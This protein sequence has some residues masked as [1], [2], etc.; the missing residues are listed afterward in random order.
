MNN[1]G[2]NINADRGNWKFSGDMIQHFPNHIKR[3]VPFYDEGHQLI[4]RLSDYFIRSGSKMYDLGCSTG[5]LLC[6]LADYHSHKKELSFIGI[7]SEPDMISFANSQ[8]KNS[9]DITF[10]CEDLSSLLFEESSLIISYYCFQFIRPKYR[11]TI[12]DRIYNALDWGGACV[13]FDKVRAPD[14]RFQDMMTGI[15]TDFKADNL[16]TDEEIMQKSRSLRGVQEPYSSEENY[17]YFYRAGFK[18][19]MTIYKYVTFEG[20]LAIK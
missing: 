15:Y 19:V 4:C 7:D 1:V 18:D 16:F 12:Y 2:D 9:S 17:R 8:C 10:L 3:S 20:F 11:Q 5:D 14:A 6:K 13:V